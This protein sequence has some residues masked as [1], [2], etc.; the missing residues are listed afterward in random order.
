MY[1]VLNCLADLS[2]E[3]KE[4]FSI[5]QKK[6]PVEKSKILELSGMKLTTLNRLMKPLLEQ[7]LIVES[8]IGESSG[9]R[10]P[11]LYSVN[12]NDYRI[13]GIDLSR[14][15]SEVAIVN[16]RMDILFKER[17]E[18]DES[19]TP[20]KTLAKITVIIN[21]GLRRINTERQKLLGIGVG[22]VGPIDRHNGVII[23]P[24][25]FPA[26]G[27]LNIPVKSIFSSEFNCP[28]SIDNGANT[29]VLS[30]YLFGCGKEND[31]IVYFNCGIGIRTGVI[32]NGKIIRT[33]YDTE[34]V[35]GHMTIDVDGEPCSCGNFGC[36]ERYSSIPAITKSFITLYQFA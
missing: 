19:F 16:L 26:H 24:V 1:E 27:W 11:A 7:K 32:S 9:G 6:G 31:S 10:K 18:M 29:A 28:V 34:D 23:N 25:N 15:Y 3:K 4:L 20:D 17:F 13:V 14:T 36:I 21:E 8:G 22:T 33:M 2:K 35:F 5:I 30:E 12:T